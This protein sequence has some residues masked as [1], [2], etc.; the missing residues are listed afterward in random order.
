[1]RP[2][3]IP[4]RYGATCRV[5]LLRRRIGWWIRCSVPSRRWRV[6]VVLRPRRRRAERVARAEAAT[7][8]AVL[9]VEVRSALLAESLQ[10]GLVGCGDQA[11]LILCWI[12]DKHPVLVLLLVI[13]LTDGWIFAGAGDAYDG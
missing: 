11:S 10:L 12:V 6:R 3:C 13:E 4:G 5:L 2:F 1:M 8:T 7:V 9:P